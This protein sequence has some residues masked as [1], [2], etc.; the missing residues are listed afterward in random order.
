MTLPSWAKQGLALLADLLMAIGVV[1]LDFELDEYSQTHW[2]P[3]A[4]SVRL[5]AFTALTFIAVSLE[6]KRD[7]NQWTFW[8]LTTTLLI[9]HLVMYQLVLSNSP[10]WPLPVFAAIALIETPCLCVL[11]DKA[12]FRPR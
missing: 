7:W 10:T 4:T 3:D 2:L 12:G 6:F 11:L 9:V 5:A 1:Y 8:L